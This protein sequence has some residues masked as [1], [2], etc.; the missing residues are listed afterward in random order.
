MKLPLSLSRWSLYHA[1]AC[2]LATGA[3]LYWVASWPL[4]CTG[5]ASFGL[6][7]ISQRK[8]W[9]PA[10]TWGVANTVTLARFGLIMSIFLTGDMRWG[11]AYVLVA[12]ITVLVAD[13]WDGWLARKRNEVSEFGEYFDKESD[14]FFVLVLCLLAYT[15]AL[16]GA[17][18]LIP[19]LLRYLFVLTLF[20]LKP[21]LGKEYRSRWARVIYV[22]MVSALMGMFVL[23]DYLYSPL[24]IL[25]TIALLLSFGHYF[26]WLAIETIKFKPPGNGTMLILAL[27]AFFLLNSL[28]LFPSYWANVSTSTFFPIPDP[29][30]PT[31]TLTWNRGWYDYF[32]YFFIRRPNQDLF[33]LC[34][35]MLVIA[36]GLIIFRKNNKLPVIMTVVYISLFVYELY[37]AAAFAFFHRHGI[38][39]E[40][41][42][43]MVNL[44]YLV[45]DAISLPH[46]FKMICIATLTILFV[47][48]LPAVFR[49][50]ARG[51]SVKTAR[52]P[53]IVLSAMMWPG[54]LGAMLWFGLSDARTTVRSVTGKFATNI[55]DSFALAQTLAR[56]EQLPVDSVYFSYDTRPM[57]RRPN[58][59]LFMV[60]SYG[61]ILIDNPF[62]RTNYSAMM[63]ET[64]V[65]LRDSGWYAMTQYSE[66]PV[67]GGL[68]WLSM[69]T[70]LSGLAM[71]NKT[72]Y[73]RYQ[74]RIEQ[75]P[76]L[77][78]Y[79]K[80]QQYHTLTL[81]PP[82]R[83]RPGLPVLNQYAFNDAIFFEELNY[84]GP[85]YSIWVIPD[86]YS[87]G[88][89]HQH[90]LS[91]APEPY[92][93][94]FET[95]T[96]HAP[97][98]NQ[99]PYLDDWQ[100]LNNA[101]PVSLAASNAPLAEQVK[102]SFDNRFYNERPN[103]VD[104]YWKSIAYDL[105]VL[106]DYV[107]NDAPPNSLFIILGDHQPP[108]LP[109]KS[110]QTP[111]HIISRDSTLL[112]DLS[113]FEF[114]PGMLRASE[115]VTPLFHSGLYSMLIDLLTKNTREI[116]KPLP[117]RKYR[118]K[119][120]TPSLL[121]VEPAR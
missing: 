52:K 29:A 34:V 35:D 114:E 32:L 110:Y 33:R 83:A 37:D 84:Q 22:C 46:A 92:F 68:S 80:Q 54:I 27:L 49:M 61:R 113:A 117:T 103:T 28:L 95:A 98:T 9:T 18:I 63:L 41:T 74:S 5:L 4:A 59:Y 2:L 109:S 91:H 111:I 16:A 11:G 112:E 104:L 81:Q 19:G 17:W 31:T 76:H 56:I 87:L 26:K 57:T 39:Y 96:T 72:F 43:Y 71:A 75:Y 13:G 25:A 44:Y 102:T 8:K 120:I 116:S 24:I 119:G 99:P 53:G 86:Q 77:V 45:I 10:G 121:S 55:S 6:L 73:A 70:V 106:R 23:P 115:P 107:L 60:E 94:F 21:S 97:W 62:L 42:Q 65:A 90:Y 105:R 69:N 108:L 15:Q 118:P 47:W 30:H 20:F 79:L 66:A 85:A 7:T 50:I 64:E 82:N 67:T 38:L 58:I 89:T 40:D 48:T 88:Y 36:T 78:R 14:A 101:E 12:G 100:D 93:L 51:F 1:W 3:A